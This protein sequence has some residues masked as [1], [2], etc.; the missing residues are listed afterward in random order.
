MDV[1]T[2]FFFELG[3]YLRRFLFPN[4]NPYFVIDHSAYLYRESGNS[5]VSMYLGERNHI[6][7]KHMYGYVTFNVKYVLHFESK[8]LYKNWVSNCRAVG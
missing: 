1:I 7:S 5:N 6:F 3:A 4:G 2:E 8:I